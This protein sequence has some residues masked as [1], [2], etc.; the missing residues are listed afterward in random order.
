MFIWAK[1]FREHWH[2]ACFQS[3]AIFVSVAIS[4]QVASVPLNWSKKEITAQMLSCE[5]CK[6]SHKTFFKEPF[7]WLLLHKHLF[8]LLP[9]H[10]L[11]SFQK[12][13]Q[14]YF[15]A[16]Y[17]LVLIWRLVT[18]VSS[19]FQTLTQKPIFNP[20]KNLRWRFLQKCFWK[21]LKTSWRRLED[22]WPR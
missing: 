16:K 20:L 12:Q 7:G 15:P 10:D 13:C 21:M 18:R 4:T 3:K 1:D 19:I 22:V 11:L 9:H 2:W 14:T 5:L 8:C 6:I 17:F